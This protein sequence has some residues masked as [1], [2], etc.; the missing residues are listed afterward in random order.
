MK[1]RRTVTLSEDLI[2]SINDLCIISGR[3]FSAELRCLLAIGISVELR[4]K[5]KSK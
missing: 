3:E 2:D 5:E 1:I 4:N